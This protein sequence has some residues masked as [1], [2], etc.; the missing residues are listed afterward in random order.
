MKI[1]IIIITDKKTNIEENLLYIR[2]L[3]IPKEY[4]TDVCVMKK[5][6]N[7][8]GDADY[9]LFL[10]ENMYITDRDILVK[11]IGAFEENDKMGAIGAAGIKDIKPSGR[12]NDSVRE[13]AISI[14]DGINAERYG[15]TPKEGDYNSGEL[16]EV[17]A[18]A[19]LIMVKGN[20][21]NLYYT[22]EVYD[23]FFLCEEI[24]EKGYGTYVLAQNKPIVLHEGNFEFDDGDEEKRKKYLLEY[25]RDFKWKEEI[26]V[27]VIIPT[28]NRGYC[29]K[30]AVESV[31]NQTYKNLEVVVVDDGSTDNTE[32]VVSSVNDE[33]VRFVKMPQNGGP[34]AA[35]NFGV[36]NARYDIIA[37]HDSDDVWR[38]EKLERQMDVMMRTGCDM[39]YGRFS[40]HYFLGSYDVTNPPESIS[41]DDK[42]NNIYKTILK[43]NII[44]MPTIVVKKDIFES[45]G[46]FNPS[47]NIL[48]DY[49]MCLRLVSAAKTGFLNEPVIDVYATDGSVSANANAYFY[50][51]IYILCLHM[52]N[53]QKFEVCNEV[54]RDIY[55]KADELGVLEP[56]EELERQMLESCGKEMYYKKYKDL[57]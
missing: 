22:G 3:S 11:F 10:T 4:E 53:M 14:F 35:R 24:R 34:A 5:G 28:Y 21:S 8:E 47:L 20:I 32:E 13:G 46:G 42:T 57:C 39:V 48:E 38:Y 23:S 2:Q 1:S 54:M 40:Y 56:V 18:L 37:F 44:A 6:E 12:W 26:P 25:G 51:R 15:S 50:S 43:Q 16:K 33:R 36:K 55:G 30:R 41:I 49:E 9:K 27:S 31:L 7:P 45:A 29:I 52:E 17:K 19:G